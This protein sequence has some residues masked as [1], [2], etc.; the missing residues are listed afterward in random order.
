LFG[1]LC[2]H[3]FDCSLVSTYINE[4]QVSSSDTYM[5]WLRNSSQFLW[6]CSKSDSLHFVHTHEHFQS[7]S[8]AN[9][10]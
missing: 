9:F 10:W 4:T 1:D 3:W 6:Y 7:P 2:I 5:M 8:C